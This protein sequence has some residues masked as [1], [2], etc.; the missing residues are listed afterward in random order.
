MRNDRIN[1]NKERNELKPFIYRFTSKGYD[2]VLDIHTNKIFFIDP[3]EA[4]V[5]DR[6]LE[7]QRL[8]DLSKKYP[9]EVAKIQDLMEGGLFCPERPEGLMFGADRDSIR[10]EILHQR[11]HTILELTQQ[12]N[13]RCR[14]CTFG[15]GF[16]DH[17]THNS[18][19][20]SEE[21]VFASIDSA[22]KHGD[23]LDEIVIGFYGGEPLLEWEL[24]KKA[25]YYAEENASGKK[26]RYSLTTNATLL[27]EEKAR[28]LQRFGAYV[29]VSLDGPKFVHDQ[30]RLFPGGEGSYEKT[31]NGLRTL[32]DI[33][34]PEEHSFIALNMVVPSMEWFGS[35][36]QL[37]ENEPWLPRTIRAQATLVDPPE[38]F[39]SPLCPSCS[40]PDQFKE[41]WLDHIERNG[42]MNTTL[43]SELFDIPLAKLH[44]RPIFRGHRRNFFPN[45]CCIPA[46]RRIYVLA[47]GTYKL[48]ER[49]HGLPSIGNVYD[50]IDLREVF[51][52]INDYCINSFSDCRKCW[53]ISLC[54]LCYHDA[55]EGGR[56]SIEKK[57]RACEANKASLASDLELFGLIAVEHPEKLDDWDE[58]AIS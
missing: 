14:Y 33:Y 24:L 50:G 13:L 29:L 53:A 32:L 23:R 43:G 11:K 41:K 6:W 15:G 47:D 58:V 7:G 46:T 10:E 51:R 57:R 2:F 49:V 35:M 30:Y 28:F 48:C 42:S 52:I 37:W 40:N 16:P 55:Y 27:N 25:V 9:E 36:E 45:G 19:T 4:K 20:M 38:G 17:R 18:R 3:E 1:F 22:L 56:F 39:C 31:I 34:P 5:V 26:I 54:H 21:V 12:C 8:I 44:Q